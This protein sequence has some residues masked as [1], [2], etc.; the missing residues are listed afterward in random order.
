MILIETITDE[1]LEIIE[2]TEYEEYLVEE[3]IQ[4]STE[5]PMIMDKVEGSNIETFYIERPDPEALKNNVVNASVFGLSVS[6]EVRLRHY[7]AV[8]DSK[9][10]VTCVNITK[11]DNTSVNIGYTNASSIMYVDIKV[12]Y[13]SIGDMYEL[14]ISTSASSSSYTLCY[15]VLTYCNKA[16]EL[17]ADSDLT[18]LCN[19]LYN[20][21]IAVSSY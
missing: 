14:K 20:F 13:S 17:N 10:T 21:S 4:L 3:D 2:D 15:G 7:F 19:A 1:G 12:P 16:R 8:N 6:D 18:N 11:K 5:Y 9:F